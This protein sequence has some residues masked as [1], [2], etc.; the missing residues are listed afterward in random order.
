MKK[1]LKGA[2]LVEALV[3]SVIF[4]TVFFIAMSSMTDIARVN[5]S[6][7]SPVDMEEAVRQCL[8]SFAAGTADKASYAYMWGDIEIESEPYKAAD[9]LKDVTVTAKAKN[10][11]TVIYRYLICPN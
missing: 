8:E 4:L 7:A 6:G 10:G 9:D 2:S 11:C 5:L 1:S 3:A